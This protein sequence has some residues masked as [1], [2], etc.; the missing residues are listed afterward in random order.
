MEDKFAKGDSLARALR[1][2]GL[3]DLLDYHVLIMG[4]QRRRCL[5][6]GRFLM[7]LYLTID[8]ARLCVET[9][10]KERIV[11][12]LA[13][14]DAMVDGGRS[15]GALCPELRSFLRAINGSPEDRLGEVGLKPR[16]PGSRSA[17]KP[18]AL[19]RGGRRVQSLLH[20]L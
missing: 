2:Q 8:L 15:G 18:D 19:N 13:E 1:E 3:P 4:S 10:R 5:K 9:G 14:V 7:A 20:L 11:E 12:L 6:E 17:P 16:R